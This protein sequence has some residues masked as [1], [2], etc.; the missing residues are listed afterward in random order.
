MAMTQLFRTS[1]PFLLITLIPLGLQ[2]QWYAAA[3]RA[4]GAAWR[5]GDATVK[6]DR[7]TVP[8]ARAVAYDHEA[9]MEILASAPQEWNAADRT[10]STLPNS[11]C[12]LTLPVPGGNAITGWEPVS[13]RVV[14]SD[15]LH[16]DLAARY[17]QISSY[18]IQSERNG[19]IFGR[20][21]LGDQ[22]FHGII[23]TEGGT[24]YLDPGTAG[25]PTS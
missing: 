10:G 17:P 13:F 19:L 12:I 3:P 1:L 21:D 20:I 24:V 6:Q 22:G 18:L 23:H 8:E 25:R 9:L 11:T 15:V 14:R 16:P 4:E 7:E 5:V 2:A